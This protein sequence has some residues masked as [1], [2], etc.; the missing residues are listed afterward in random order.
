MGLFD[1]IAGNVLGSVLGG[2]QGGGNNPLGNILG[3]VLSGGSQQEASSAVG[4]IINASG[5][6]GGLLEKAKSMGMGDVVGSW[7]GKGE[8]QPIDADQ[9]T[10]LLGEDAVAGVASKFGLD[11]KQ[12]GPLIAAMLPVI[13]DKLTPHGEVNPEQHSGEGLQNAVSGLLSGGGLSSILASIMGGGG[14]P[15]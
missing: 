11:M 14:K 2:Q 10:Q 9:A 7:I 5:G 13:I 8:N 15:A 1:S 6:I 4:N 3:A 12:A